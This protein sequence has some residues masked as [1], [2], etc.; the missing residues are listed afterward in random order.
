[1]R[2]IPAIDLRDGCCVQLVGGD[3]DRECVR[4]PNV[5]RVVRRWQ[6]AGFTEIHLVDLDAAAGRRGNTKL[7]RRIIYASTTRVQF[8]GGVRDEPSVRAWL[9]AGAASVV[10]GTRALR[11]TSW[12]ATVSARFPGRI[13]LALD[14]R[15][16]QP[17]IDAWLRAA[18]VTID[19]MLS[20]MHKLPLGGILVTAVHREGLLAG[21][22]VPLIQSVKTQ[23]R[24]PVIAAGGIASLDD[25]RALEG[26]GASA[27]VVG[28]ALY[29]GALDPVA[30]VKE[31]AA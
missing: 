13:V 31:F 2:V 26:A 24:H 9:D 7:A 25:L 17:V 15:D 10:I 21:P 22:D 1:M 20:C 4:I 30:L 8:G 27:V 28:T 16:R 3:F 18:P 12:L 6:S 11:D 29:S 14:V 19:A 5:M 23:T